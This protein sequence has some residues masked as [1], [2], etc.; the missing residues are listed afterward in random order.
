MRSSKKKKFFGA[1]MFVAAF[2]AGI[3]ITMLLWNALIPDIIGWAAINYWQAA[4][5]LILSRLLFGGFG[6]MRRFRENKEH[7]FGHH[8][9]EKHARIHEKLRCM[10]RDERREYI[11]RQMFSCAPFSEAECGKEEHSENK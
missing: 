11:R 4:G 3:A 9:R 7:W 10:S 5:L 8:D 2:A 1:L 6:R